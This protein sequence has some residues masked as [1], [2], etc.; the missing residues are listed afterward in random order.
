MKVPINFYIRED[1]VQISQDLLGKVLCTNIKGQISKAIITETEAYA[2]IND[3]ASHAH[4]GRRTKRTE[5]LYAKGGTAYVYLCYGIHHLFNVVTNEANTPHAVLIRAGEPLEGLVHMRKRRNR[6]KIDRPLLAGP[7][8]LAK[9]LGITTDLTGIC[10]LEN[11][12]W[13]E[14]QQ[15]TI[16]P[17]SVVTGPRVGIDYAEEDAQLPYRFRLNMNELSRATS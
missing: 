15:S 12:I 14:D 1:V 6:E 16:D 8:I 7:G 10:L 9:A 5:P 11:R 3:K 2:G 13:I 17:N 4:G